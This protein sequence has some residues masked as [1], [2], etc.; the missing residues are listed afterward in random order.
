MIQYVQVSNA[1]RQRLR[2]SQTDPIVP[3]EA[4]SVKITLTLKNMIFRKKEV[5]FPW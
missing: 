1:H 2:R 4:G 5:F 3:S